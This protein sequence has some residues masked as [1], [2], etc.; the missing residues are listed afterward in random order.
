[1]EL[2]PRIGVGKL[3]FGMKRKDVVTMLGAPDQIVEDEHG[4]YGDTELI[5][6]WNDPR[7]RLTFN[8]KLDEQ[9]VYI[10][11]KSR[12]LMYNGRKIIDEKIEIVKNEVFGDLIR[13]WDTDHY[14]SFNTYF[15]EKHW[16]SLHVEFGVVTNV[17][18]G[19]PFH[20]REAFDWPIDM[21]LP[22]N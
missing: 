9:L 2:K 7:L 1:M 4:R 3:R 15:N 17:E 16:L 10:Q 22:L 21:T 11:T 20:H 14:H 13:E 6:D 12:G 5:L 18:I 19:V 8:K